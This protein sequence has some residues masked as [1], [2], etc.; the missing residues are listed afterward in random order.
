[1]PTTPEMSMD[2]TTVGD[3]GLLDT[4]HKNGPPPYDDLWKYEPA[5]SHE[6]DWNPYPGL[7]RFQEKGEMPGNIFVKEYSLMEKLH[8]LGGFMDTFS[9]LYPQLKNVNFLRD[10]TTLEV[11]VYMIQG[12]H[13]ARGRAVPADQWF[14]RLKAPRKQRFVFDRSGHKAGFE[15]PA[16]FQRVMTTV[17]AQT[18]GR[19]R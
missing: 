10:A 19:T 11:P 5:L 17:L 7:E 2:M 9:V 15:Q 14:A 4:L 6:H 13:E 12:A 18:S 16:D 3:T 8:T 1:M